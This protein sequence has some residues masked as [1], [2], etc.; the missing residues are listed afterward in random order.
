[1]RR[2]RSISCVVFVAL[3]FAIPAAA[4]PV[5]AATWAENG[6]QYKVILAPSISWDAA[7]AAAADLADGSWHLAT[8]ASEAEQKFIEGLSLSGEAVWLG[9][10]Q[11]PGN[12]SAGEGW[13]W[14][15]GE[16]LGYANWAPGEANDYRGP[17][18]EQHLAMWADTRQW[19][20]EGNLRNI[21]GFLVESSAA[22][23]PEPGTMMLVGLAGG[24]LLTRY[25]RRQQQS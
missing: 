19:N 22:P 25:R 8:I 10:F 9:G 23:V 18:S 6:H 3:A 21:A 7:A 11:V 13:S 12:S 14:V 2:V 15:T 4:D 24:A 16:S 1:M 17:G 20:D 5:P